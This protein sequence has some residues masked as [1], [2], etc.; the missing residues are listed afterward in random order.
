M[1]TTQVSSQSQFTNNMLKKE[2]YI[3]F[4]P[5]IEFVYN[6]APMPVLD[7]QGCTNKAPSKEDFAHVGELI[8]TMSN[9]CYSG[10]FDYGYNYPSKYYFSGKT[11]RHWIT[12]NQLQNWQEATA[13]FFYKKGMIRDKC[14][15]TGCCATLR[16]DFDFDTELDSLKQ[17]RVINET[18]DNNL[19]LE[20][21]EDRFDDNWFVLSTDLSTVYTPAKGFPSGL[22]AYNQYD[23][24][25]ERICPSLYT[26]YADGIRKFYYDM[27]KV[28]KFV[29]LAQGQ[30]T[31][32]TVIW[33]GVTDRMNYYHPWT[34]TGAGADWCSLIWGWHGLDG[35]N[36][37]TSV[38]DN[39][40]SGDFL[41]STYSEVKHTYGQQ[42]PYP[43]ARSYYWKYNWM[44]V[45]RWQEGYKPSDRQSMGHYENSSPPM[46][47]TSPMA[48]QILRKC[49]AFIT[50][51]C[52]SHFTTDDGPTYQYANKLFELQFHS[53]YN[54]AADLW[55]FK[56]TS[57]W[58]SS[59]TIGDQIVS[60][61]RKH[62]NLYRTWINCNPIIY[63]LFELDLDKYKT[64]NW[65]W[66]P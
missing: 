38:T 1:T 49:Y 27:D 15:K 65:N 41:S 30:N 40:L 32:G 60:E 22:S 54:S 52:E 18:S 47:V 43:P 58:M 13:S 3:Y 11:A 59:K 46:F 35:Q 16:P 36:T 33:G 8:H 42:K 14:M 56:N 66:Q 29:V 17:W 20:Y 5:D 21:G 45:A 6:G 24:K 9:A 26:P 61:I 50:W 62:S 44:N 63:F 48:T 53:H 39:Y 2:D 12:P 10:R 55:T 57:E 19:S 31:D 37:L 34:G 64:Q 4:K 7:K 51:Q 28:G 25:Q 23:N